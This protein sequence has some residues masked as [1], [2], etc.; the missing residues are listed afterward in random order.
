MGAARGRLFGVGFVLPAA[1]FLVLVFL[2]PLVR[3]LSLSLHPVD[4]AGNPLPEFSLVQYQRVFTESF[5]SQA[6][7]SSFQTSLLVT[8]LCLALGYP[9][10]YAL[11]RV[12]GGALRTLM[13]VIV[14]S[15]LLTSV[16]VRS[17]GWVVLLSAN[18]VVNRFLVG[19][20]IA[21]QPLPLLTSYTAVVVS[22][23]HVLLPFAIIPLTTALGGIDP[24]LRR[25]SQSLG[26]GPART[27]GRVTLPLSLPGVAAACMVVFPLSMGIYITPLLVGGANQPLAGLRV[28]S[29]ITSVYDYPV[30]A[31]LSLTL[32]VLTLV[33]VAAMGAG[34]RFWERRNHG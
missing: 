3:V 6:L 13:F 11:S 26:A 33:C 19:T 22:V 23:T 30:A 27:F 25:A 15:P 2:V 1:V 32:L 8:A 9:V 4:G 20:G 10:A 16:V 5:F 28:Y 24:H 34:F 12:P 31:A 7:V 21:D 18:G 14:L 29:Q 17:Y